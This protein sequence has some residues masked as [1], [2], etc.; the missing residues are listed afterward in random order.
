MA[1][2]VVK[3]N[4]NALVVKH[5][6]LIQA[7]YTLTLQEKRVILWLISEIDQ[8]DTD[9][10]TYRVQVKD[11]ADFIG[12]DRNG[13]IYAQI[14]DVTKKLMRRV[15]EISDV[16]SRKLLQVAWISSAEYHL[17]HGYVDLCFDPKLK[18]YLL[19][20]KEQFTQ[21]PLKYVLGLSS[22][23]AIRFYE[24]LKQYER[25]GKREITLEDLKK[26]V[27]AEGKYEKIK[28]FRRY[29]IEIA[30]REIN[31]K[32]DIA[33][34]FEEIKEGRKIAS[35]KFA[36]RKNSP[37][38]E[39]I[40]GYKDIAIGLPQDTI[41][42]RLTKGHGLSEKEATAAIEKLGE[43]KVLE[44]VATVEAAAKA[45]ELKK[46]ALAFLRHL[47]KT[48]DQAAPTLFDLELEEGRRKEQQKA[49]KQRTAQQERE[50]QIEAQE[51]LERAY[52]KYRHGLALERFAALPEDR[53]EALK[54]S[55]LAVFGNTKTLASR[56]K[57]D[58]LNS[59]LVRSAFAGLIADK[60][61]TKAENLSL[62]AFQETRP[63]LAAK[64]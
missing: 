37:L 40:A 52:N 39:K 6:K 1:Y 41:F 47:I 36:I 53:Q 26:M 23:Y 20:L 22:T 3:P 5:N 58:G 18:P 15:M 7:R 32:T 50:R 25:I 8:S 54:E 43:A 34:D 28:D 27:G 63:D 51:A 49:D 31:T 48:T 12:V 21:L 14:A 16:D 11:L 38:E 64:G 33:F 24:L 60:V 62:E 17:G 2:K 9:F 44:L 19:L 57:K 13:N 29:A 59:P 55:F 45:G 42:L 56:Y 10:K 46:S 30:Q 35:I 4:E 61:L